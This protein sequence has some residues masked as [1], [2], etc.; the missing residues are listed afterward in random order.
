MSNFRYKTTRE[1]S[2]NLV[3]TATVMVLSKKF[4]QHE[5]N[6]FIASFVAPE[7]RIDSTINA[8]KEESKRL[9]GVDILKRMTVEHY[10]AILNSLEL[11][12][13]TKRFDKQEI[14]KVVHLFPQSS[15]SEVEKRVE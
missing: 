8:I 13:I 3:W 12:V 1:M 7:D 6:K 10:K 9:G 15:W 5:I 11:M 4:T 2:R 14:T